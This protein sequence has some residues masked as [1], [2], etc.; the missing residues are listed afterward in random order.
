MYYLSDEKPRLIKKGFSHV[1]FE[2]K[3]YD[4]NSDS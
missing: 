2:T 3:V 1:N 4:F